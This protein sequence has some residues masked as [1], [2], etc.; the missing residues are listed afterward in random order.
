MSIPVFK[1]IEKGPKDIID[2]DYDCKN[3]LK[4]KTPGPYGIHFTTA[5][6]H[7]LGK[8]AGAKGTVGGKISLK[9]APPSG[10]FSVDKFE[11]KP[12]GSMA[13][14]TSLVGV[15][16]GLKLE[17]KGDDSYKGD[18]SMVY[19]TPLLSA[20]AELDL[21]EFSKIKGS[22]TGVQKGV[23]GGASVALDLPGKKD[24]VE[25]SAFDVALSYSLP[26]NIFA[27]LKTSNKFGVFNFSLSHLY[28]TNLS[29][30]SMISMTPKGLSTLT[31]GGL[32]KCNPATALKCK[33]NNHGVIACSVKQALENKASATLAAEVCV[34]DSKS[35]K[36]G[37][38]AQLG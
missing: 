12:D 10:G 32:Y 26:N 21:V 14:E 23:T 8:T 38:T 20:T 24:K 35:F 16:P 31:L 22:I 37:L 9:Y 28:A 18:L 36:W 33:V 2:E 15:S 19:K 6:E 25:L 11:V 17:F 29:L 34:S 3:V 27:A 4:V 5:S 7:K 13:I 1:D 30:A